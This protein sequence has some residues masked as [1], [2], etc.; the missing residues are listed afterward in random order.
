MKQK[1]STVFRVFST[2]PYSEIEQEG[3]H[4]LFLKKD[5]TLKFSALSNTKT[6]KKWLFLLNN[7]DFI[8]IFENKSLTTYFQPILELNNMQ[9]KAYECLTRGV[10]ADGNLMAPNLLLN[11]Q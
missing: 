5:E 6:L 3:I 1:I 7:V 11:L 4:V 8:N 2:Q 10:K 9:I